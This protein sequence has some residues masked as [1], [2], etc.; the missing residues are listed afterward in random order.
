MHFFGSLSAAQGSAAIFNDHQPLKMKETENR[1]F[2][3]RG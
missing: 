1:V 3:F 2:R